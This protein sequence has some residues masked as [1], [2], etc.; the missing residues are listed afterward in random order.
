MHILQEKR[1]ILVIPRLPGSKY[2]F[3]FI[4]RIKSLIL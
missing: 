4:D 3:Q 2:I 1:K